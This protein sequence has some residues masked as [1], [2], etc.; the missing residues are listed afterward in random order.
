M[1]SKKSLAARLLTRAFRPRKPAPSRKPLGPLGR[2][3]E[4]L[5][6]RAVPAAFT[7]GDLY[8]ASNANGTIYNISAGGN[9]STLQPF[10]TGLL[11]NLG[12]IAWSADLSTM[13]T[14]A[15]YGG[16]YVFAVTAAGA[17]S[18]YAAVPS[19]LG[20]VRT[21]NNHLLVSS[22]GGPI[23]D[24]TN[25]AN[26]T[27]FAS[28]GDSIRNLIQLPTGEILAMGTH[29]RIYRVSQGQSQV[30]ATVAG[31]GDGDDIDYTSDGRVYASFWTGGSP[32]N[33]AIYDVT[34]GGTIT[35]A[36]YAT[37]SA[38]G[39]TFGLAID[40]RTNH[41]LAA[42]LSQT[43]VLDV[44]G[45]GTFDFT[46]AANNPPSAVFARNIPTTNDTALDFVPFDVTPPTV[47][48][49]N[50][51]LSGGTLAGGAT[52]LQVSFSEPVVGAA[53][54]ANYELRSQ[55]ADGILGNGDDTIV[56][57]SPS[58]AGT[59]ATLNFSALPAGV[60]R[61]TV[62]GTIADAAGNAL[63]GDGN[64]TAGGDYVRDFVVGAS[65]TTLTGPNGSAFDVAYGGFGAGQLVQGT[66]NAFDGLNRLQV[67]G[68][69]YTPPP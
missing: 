61:L 17:V 41:I 38:G 15:Y 67:G 51:S 25:P 24:I 68:A 42:G 44:T 55:G 69:D 36:P 37:P 45:G 8:Y 52:S 65:T 27:T 2:R 30:W 28:T 47:I 19:P 40:R 7:P 26:I 58:Y 9:L 32:I 57:V 21:Q 14:T 6:D 23:L 43:F 13:Y 35:S 20:L 22:Y 50:P 3:I 12:Q 64:G 11:Q 60:Y 31:A 49:T 56:P 10:A 18:T 1:S 5:E 46:N 4:E 33:S 34:G 53:T 59:T 62:K 16:N 66:S 48:D 54:A 39:G 29:G 63:D